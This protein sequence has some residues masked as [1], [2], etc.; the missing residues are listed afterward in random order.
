MTYMKIRVKQGLI[1]K[2]KMNLANYFSDWTLFERVWLAAFTTITISLFFIWHDSLMGLGASL[3][4]MLCVVL[5]AKGKI[6]NYYFGIVNCILYAYVAYHSK[7]YGEVLLN[8]VYFLPM[9]FLGIYYWKKHINKKKTDDDVIVEWFS[10][11]DRLIWLGITL[12]GTAGVGLFLRAIG[13]ELPYIGA[14]TA[15]L[16]VIAMILTVRRVAEEWILWIIVDI[17]TIYMWIYS[18][19]QGGRD[20]TILIMWLAFLINAVYGFF[21]WIRLA[22]D[23][24]EV[25]Q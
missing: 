10:W 25:K 17:V 6:S 2:I 4:G 8:I 5:T 24:E 20:I 11:K 14:F 18:I 9:Q 15:T 7:Y 1:K 16:S 22:R 19:D 23:A 13:S 3:T 21:N 12:A